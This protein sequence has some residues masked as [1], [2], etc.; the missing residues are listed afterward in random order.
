MVSFR[1]I[2]TL[3]ET[4][5]ATLLDGEIHPSFQSFSGITYHIAVAFRSARQFCVIYLY[6]YNGIE[7]CTILLLVAV[8]LEGRAGYSLI[9]S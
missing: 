1:R 2:W 9:A 8:W 7:V 5:F 4:P 6:I 3:N